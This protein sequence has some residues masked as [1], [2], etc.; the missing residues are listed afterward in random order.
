MKTIKFLVQTLLIAVPL[1]FASC[2]SDDDDYKVP[3]SENSKVL[4]ASF[5]APMTH[6]SDQEY[7]TIFRYDE[8]NQLKEAE[9]YGYDKNTNDTLTWS[10]IRKKFEFDRSTSG[11]IIVKIYDHNGTD[12][13]STA[14]NTV[15]LTLNNN[16]ITK[17]EHDYTTDYYSLTWSG[18]K[19][20]KV[21]NSNSSTEDRLFSYNIDGNYNGA[22]YTEAWGQEYTIESVFGNKAN[23]YQ[24]IP[25]E[26][27]FAMEHSINEQV[28][29]LFRCFSTNNIVKDTKTLS[30]ERFDASGNKHESQ[31]IT[32]TEYTYSYT[33]SLTK[34]FP[35]KAI[36]KGE[37]GKSINTDHSTDPA[38]VTEYAG[39][40]FEDVIEF[41]YIKK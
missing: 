18:N 21:N 10:M 17:V 36:M 13:M 34:D 15:T 9:T 6:S 16:K 26:Y 14:N 41:T 28:C 25:C 11:K 7:G 27:I 5:R 12:W 39:T 23:F 24:L 19:L 2:S 40:L 3:T 20:T 31:Y 38:T 1:V 35:S 33:S 37:E 22:T 4:L 29:P 30:N 32:T 8:N